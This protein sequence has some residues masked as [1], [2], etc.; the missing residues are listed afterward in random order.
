ML[1]CMLQIGFCF[2][3]S[4]QYLNT[5]SKDLPCVD[6]V[7]NLRIIMTKD[8]STLQP[9]LLDQEVNQILKEAS[10]YFDAIC[11]SFTSCDTEV[12]ENY[13]Y[14]KLSNNYYAEEV[15]VLYAYP[16]RIN[17]FFVN[18]IEFTSHCGYSYTNGIS[19]EKQAQIF[20]ELAPKNC[21]DG[22]AE[23]LAH[24]MG[25]LL[26]LRP[27]NFSS[28]SELVDGSNCDTEGDKICDTPADPFPI[29]GT[30]R[31]SFFMACEFIWNETDPNGDF[32]TPSMNNMMSPYPCKCQ[33]TYQQYLK[34]AQSYSSSPIKQ[35]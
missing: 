2:H 32:Y 7:F 12:V 5:Q 6:K 21:S 15:G 10:T 19:I 30:E 14:S 35:Y 28:G 25:R 26:G 8:S 22:P 9:L 4:G 20:I 18:E 11:M 17:V 1:L 27:T 24:H 33:F 34:M 31:D 23:Q 3:A 29:E 16:R 13:S